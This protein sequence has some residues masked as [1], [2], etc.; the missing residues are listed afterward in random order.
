MA[1]DY[2]YYQEKGR[3][4]YPETD[5]WWYVTGTQISNSTQVRGPAQ[6][7]NVICQDYPWAS[8]LKETQ[9]KAITQTSY[10]DCGNRIALNTRRPCRNNIQA[11]HGDIFITDISE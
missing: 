2:I 6:K 9:I 8:A 1:A 11:F 7:T 4:S 3:L 10:H 5:V